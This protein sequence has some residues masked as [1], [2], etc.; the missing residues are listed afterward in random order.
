MTVYVVGLDGADWSL[1]RRWMDEGSL[2]AFERLRSEGV[3]GDLRS[4]L[5]SITF[6][7]W[8]CY[9]TGKTPGKLG[10]Y[11]WFSFDRDRCEIATND[12]SDFRSREYWDVLA[13]RGRNA[14]VVNMPTTHPPR[15]AEG[16]LTV[17][18]S[19]ASERGEFT[20]P[21]SLKADLLDAVPSYRVK[22]NLVLDEA[23]P[24]ELVAEAGTLADQR[25]DAA[26]WLASDRDRDLVHLTV[27]ITDTVQHRLWDRPARIR[28]L[29]ERIDERLGR[30]L[31]D[32]ETEAVFLVSD[33]G[34]VEIRETFLVNQWLADRGDLVVGEESSRTALASLGLT[35][36]RLKRIVSRLGLV[37]LAQALVPES[38]Q[39]RFPSESGRVSVQDAP[40][41]WERTRAISLG[42]GP[43]YVN[44]RAFESPS[45]KAAYVDELASAVE[46]LETPDGTPVAA[47][48]HDPADV[49]T[50]EMERAPDLLV[51]YATGI[52]APESLGGDVFGQR[53][54]WLATHRHTGV[55]GAWGDGVADRDE[56]LDLTLYDLAPTILHYL[57]SPVPEDVD[58]DVAFEVLSGDA[59]AREVE[60]G[61]P[62]AVGTGDDRADE[63][64]VEETLKNL[65]YVE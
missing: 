20:S 55:F 58:G 12:S 37:N 41:D 64:D 65:G 52:D 9:S 5:P 42:R 57:G 21:R 33:H 36:E 2:P 54:E 62:T 19:P 4:T 61:P 18:G 1:L 44:D 51:E 47:A 60:T 10:V 34:F 56:P 63:R 24:D 8:K 30:L 22:P 49:Y 14:A 53:L 29:Y 38:V 40:V 28:R 6:P 27:F 3:V 13:D 23:S 25:F 17:A 31:D 7:A 46:S 59:S 50:G 39:R 11:E 15:T 35:E 16:V 48:V 26:E 32:P 45:A 43:V